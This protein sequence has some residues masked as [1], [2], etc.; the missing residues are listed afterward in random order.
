M[1]TLSGT[2]LK[3]IKHLV[4]SVHYIRSTELVKGPDDLRR[5]VAMTFFR[6]HLPIAPGFKMPQR[7]L[8]QG[9]TL[10]FSLCTMECFE[11][12]PL[13]LPQI[14]YTHQSVF[15]LRNEGRQAWQA[16]CSRPSKD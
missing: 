13:P 14:I 10:K 5:A 12:L 8:A 11:L 2:A 7:I 4:F 6:S 16:S 1:H 15:F 9:P 3:F